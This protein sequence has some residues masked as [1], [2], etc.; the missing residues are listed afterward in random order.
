LARQ[1]TERTRHKVLERLLHPLG[2]TGNADDPD[3]LTFT[4]RHG[5]VIDPT[6]PPTDGGAG[7]PWTDSP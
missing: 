4:D 6:P 5:R 1:A 2:I 3:G 7:N